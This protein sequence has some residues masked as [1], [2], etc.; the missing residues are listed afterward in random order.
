MSTRAVA[1]DDWLRVDEHRATELALRSRLWSERPSDVFACSPSAVP[2][3]EELTALIADWASSRRLPRPAE[4]VEPLVA[5]GLVVQED[6][7]VMQHEGGGWRLTAAMLCFP[8]HW[9]LAEKFGRLQEAVHGPVPHYQKDLAPTVNRFFDRLTPDRIM[10]RRNWGFTPDVLL[11]RPDPSLVDRPV[12]R[13]ESF[14]L[15]SER[16][17]LRRL[18][19]SGA[20]VFTIRTQL[21]PVSALRSHPAVA[22][23]LAA[24]MRA[25]S[26]EVRA[27]RRGTL[28]ELIPWLEATGAE[29]ASGG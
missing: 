12:E 25:W 27:T 26:P 18:A 5:A 16:Q 22:A 8:T 3:C 20:I 14:W 13:V 15:R 24:A 1:V 17:T 23:R 2:A 28:D 29:P 21:A 19:S 9:R 6:L 11:F 10:G 7:C 4:D